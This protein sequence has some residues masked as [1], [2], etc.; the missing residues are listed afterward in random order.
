ML[1]R[2]ARL[3]DFFQLVFLFFSSGGRFFFLDSLFFSSE[4]LFFFSIIFFITPLKIGE[5]NKKQNRKNRE[6]SFSVFSVLFSLKIFNYICY[7]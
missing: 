7:I 3:K 2:A 6:L 1:K 5:Q 4:N